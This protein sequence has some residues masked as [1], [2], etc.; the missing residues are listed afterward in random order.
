MKTATLASVANETV[1]IQQVRPTRTIPD[2]SE[3]VRTGLLHRPRSLPAK[4]FYDETGSEIFDRICDLPEYYLTRAESSLLERYADEIIA[5]SRPAEILELGSGASRKSRHLF[6]ACEGAGL[7]PLYRPFDVCVAMLRSASVSLR[8]DYPWL[9]IAP[10]AGDYMAGLQ[11][12]PVSHGPRLMVF[13]G[14]TL[15]NLDDAQAAVFLT[16][17]RRIMKPGD[18]LLLGVD[19][20]KP[21]HALHAAYNDRQGLTARFNLNLLQVLNRRLHA[22]FDLQAF[23]HYAC[24][25]PRH[26]RMEMHLLARRDQQVYFADLDAHLELAEG[27]NMLT[28]IS[29]KYSRA[30]I[31]TLLGEAGFRLLRHFAARDAGFSLLLAHAATG[32]GTGEA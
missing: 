20:L 25:N 6:D 14:S 22:D 26:A 1:A 16:E 18:R 29:C 31:D 23:E 32:A 24:F 19:R 11:N 3:D 17:L 8:Q 9:C 2:L 4:Y 5:D 30:H 27:E 10:L 13:L 15:G 7:R 28:E 21:V 12:L